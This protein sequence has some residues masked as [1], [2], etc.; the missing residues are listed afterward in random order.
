MYRISLLFVFLL[1]LGQ[2]ALAG[3]IDRER[4]SRLAAK[5][6]KLDPKA[7]VLRS[8][9]LQV[10]GITPAYHIFNDAD[11]SG[12]V[13]LSGEEGLSPVLGYSEEGLL[14]VGHMPEQLTELLRKY[15]LRI[16][17]IRR[18]AL[19]PIGQS[20]SIVVNRPKVL[21]GPLLSCTWDQSA[22]YNDSAPQKTGEGRAPTGCV[23][24]AMAQMM[25][26]HRWPESGKG[27]RTYTNAHYGELSADFSQSVYAWSSMTDSYTR[28]RFGV[29]TWEAQAASAVA[30]LMYDA[31]VSV[32]MQFT[33]QESGAYT[34][35]AAKALDEHFDY[36]I[37]FLTRDAMNNEDFVRGVKEELH[38]GNPIIMTGASKAGGHAWILDGY[39]ENGLIHVNWGWGGRSNGYFELDFMNP[40]SLGIGGGEGNFNQEQQVILARPRK[41]DATLPERLQGRF[42]LFAGGM[43]IDSKRSDLK[44]GVVQ[45]LIP[46][47]GN[48]LTPKFKGEFGV[49]LYSSDGTLEHVYTSYPLGEVPQRT[50]FTSE[51]SVRLYLT[52]AQRDLVGRYYLTPVSREQRLKTEGANPNVESSWEVTGVWL[53]MGHSN[54]IEVELNKGVITVLSDGNTPQFVLTEAPEVL[55]SIWMR[56][57]GSIRASIKNKSVVTLRG[58]VALALE[59]VGQTS[60]IRDTLALDETV[61]YDYTEV[62]R[63]LNFSTLTNR[64][65][66]PGKYYVNFCVIKPAEKYLDRNN[67]EQ[68][69]PRVVYEVENPFGRFEIEILNP[70]NSPIVEYY[71]TTNSSIHKLELF[72]NGQLYASDELMLAD[73]TKGKWAVGIGLRNYGTAL[74]TP[75][76]Y[77]LKDMTTGEVLDLATSPSLWLR[78]SVLSNSETRAEIDF[79]KVKFE[80]DHTYRILV[81][82]KIGSKWVDVWTAEAPRRYLFVKAGEGATS[83]NED[84]PT[85]PPNNVSV[86]QI[87][88]EETPLFYPNPARGLLHIAPRALGELEIFDIQGRRVLTHT[89]RQDAEVVDVSALK[90][91]VYIVK[92]TSRTGSIRSEKLFIQ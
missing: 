66:R 69:D 17:E 58:Q 72:R 74:Q 59:S 47:I 86:I 39:D 15:E 67:K 62:D 5:F 75:V 22:P 31:A 61:F 76:R 49:G 16:K 73:L 21:V 52:A 8:A 35:D 77:R 92:T 36:H 10:A 9:E 54:R 20:R 82:I 11:R 13:V 53:P 38:S 26:F 83:T 81:E 48:W 87:E 14:Q 78:G 19:A 68:I 70:S 64:K 1:Q 79:G 23:A 27:S 71:T 4:A 41:A 28:N 30:Q 56:R 37:R 43:Y 18:R 29:A 63:P 80:A 42:S 32:Q 34:H 40:P 90:M 84:E 2:S 6:V 12:F 7:E 85:T 88:E 46:S 33:P 55:S 24:T 50:Y 91:G 3:P 44:N 60:P 25:Y 45:F 57:E 51:Q 65:L 89:L